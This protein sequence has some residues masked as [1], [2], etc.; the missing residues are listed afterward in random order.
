MK[1]KKIDKRTYTKNLVTWITIN[2]TV[3]VYMTYILAFTGREQIAESLSSQVVDVILGT[4][5]MYS[6]KALFENIFKYRN[7][8][9]DKSED[10]LETET[11]E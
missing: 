9:D 3:W 1:K 7:R 11:Y 4:V 10:R 5:L 8:K 2:A 6:I